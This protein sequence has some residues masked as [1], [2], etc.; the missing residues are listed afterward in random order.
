M[1]EPRPHGRLARFFFMHLGTLIGIVV[2]IVLGEA[3]A[4]S[5]DGVARALWAALGV[6]SAYM[7]VAFTHGELKQ[8]DVAFWLLYAT[9]ALAAAGGASPVLG[10]FQRYAGALIFSTL[11]LTALV[12]LLLGRTPF[13]VYHAL[14]QAPRWQW[15]TPSFRE[16]CRVM[17][18]F[19]VLVFAVGAALCIARPTDPMFTL[20]YPNLL[21]FLIGLPA[22]RWLPPLWLQRF[23]PPLPDTAEALIM[24]MPFALDPVAARDARAVIEFRVSGDAPG[25][26]WLQVGGGRCESFEGRAE[27][28]DL[29]VHT[30]DHVWVG[31]AHGRLDGTQALLQG[32]YRAEGD[33]SM[34]AKLQQWFHPPMIRDVDPE[35]PRSTTG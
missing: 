8:F 30:P 1:Q 5:A 25:N 27:R 6:H 16:V 19:W 3:A 15:R 18:W 9:G 12:P 29:V 33:L 34:L 21:V 11:T 2:Y 28:P 23:P 26:Y 13:T 7:A 35:A 17:A 32:Q 10:L 4:W 24:G 31:I 20:V 22:G 14:R